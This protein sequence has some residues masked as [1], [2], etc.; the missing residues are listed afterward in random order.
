MPTATP[1]KYVCPACAQKTGVDIL[2]GLPAP[3]A[4]EAA[5]RGEVVLGGCCIDLEG[6]ER[7][8][9]SC[10]HEWRIKRRSTELDRLLAQEPRD[11]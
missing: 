2:Y 5:E 6:P 11:R 7:A 4:F 9:T 8:C 3:A 10:G 1:R